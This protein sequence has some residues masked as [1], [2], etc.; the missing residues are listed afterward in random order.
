MAHTRLKLGAAVLALAVAAPFAASAQPRVYEGP[1]G[2]PPGYGPPPPYDPDG[3][4][5]LRG[6]GVRELVPELRDSERGAR[7]VLRRFDFDHNG[8]ISREEARA[9]DEA[10]FEMRRRG[11]FEEDLGPA[12]PP[13]PPP[14]REP[15]PP[16]PVYEG[17]QDFD[18]PAMRQYHFRQG[19][20]GAVF[21]LPDVLFETAKYDLRPGA[22]ARLRPL[23]EFLKRHPRV[24]LRIDGY[25]DSV[26]SVA[27]NLTLSRNRARAVAD[28]LEVMG[29][30]ADRFELEGHG[31]ADPVATNATAEGR[32]LNRRVD[33]TLIG[34]R[35]NTFN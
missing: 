14:P 26:G 29:V 16:P 17:P 25:T 34:Q 2:P 27:Y 22:E 13:P 1:G 33:V 30:S 3:S 24:R 19:R 11:R 4:P 15:P 18:R 28:A 10:F 21:T 35:A 32:Q 20:L 23:G 5:V 8:F 9:A 6:P 31:K 12:Y 7:F